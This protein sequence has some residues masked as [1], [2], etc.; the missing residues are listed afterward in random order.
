[1][2]HDKTHRD[3]AVRLLRLADAIPDPHG[4][5]IPE[6]E[7][8]ELE[9]D[10]HLVLITLQFEDFWDWI[11]FCIGKD[12]MDKMP[13]EALPKVLNKLNVLFLWFFH[14]GQEAEESLALDW[15]S[16]M[17]DGEL[18]N[19]NCFSYPVLTAD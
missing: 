16:T 3:W 15:L 1:M 19:P 13:I 12:L 17:P 6:I 4:L 14:V 11:G 18:S 8:V 5:L 9:Q 10:C 7:Y 2:L